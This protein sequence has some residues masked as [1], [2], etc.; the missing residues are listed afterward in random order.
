MRDLQYGRMMSGEFGEAAWVWHETD[1][2]ILLEVDVA[3]ENGEKSC[4]IAQFV[5]DASG[6]TI[7]SVSTHHA[8]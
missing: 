4:L 7:L 1:G 6:E 5:P 3:M 8:A 2:E